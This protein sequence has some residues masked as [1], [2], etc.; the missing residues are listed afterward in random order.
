MLCYVVGDRLFDLVSLC[1]I[2]ERRK[3]VVVLAFRQIFLPSVKKGVIISGEQSS[4]DV[5]PKDA[6]V[7]ILSH[8]LPEPRCQIPIAGMTADAHDARSFVTCFAGFE[9]EIEPVR[10]NSRVRRWKWMSRQAP[11]EF[12]KESAFP[13]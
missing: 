6:A 5:F 8:V 9:H 7:I 3:S 2:D 1:Q 11:H 4:P 12:M 10:R 13:I